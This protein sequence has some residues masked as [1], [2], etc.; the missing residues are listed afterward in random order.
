MSVNTARLSILQLWQ[1]GSVT[2]LRLRRSPPTSAGSRLA[3]GARHAAEN[4]GGPATDPIDGAT[5]P[6]AAPGGSMMMGMSIP[7]LSPGSITLQVRAC[8]QCGGTGQ[9]PDAVAENGGVQT[10]ETY[11]SRCDGRQVEMVMP[12]GVGT[13]L[14]AMALKGWIYSNEP[15]R[16]RLNVNAPYVSDFE[17]EI[18]RGLRRYGSDSPPLS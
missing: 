5:V 9:D 7:Q 3:R 17:G 1:P 2:I 6:S 16:V 12:D 15:E 4:C 8:D 14:L 10:D 11:C 13:L 18:L